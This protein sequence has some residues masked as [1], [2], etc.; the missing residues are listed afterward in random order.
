M[1]L[2]ATIVKDEQ[3]ALGGTPAA[4]R[5]T[6]AKTSSVDISNNTTAQDTPATAATA[7]DT[8]VTTQDTPATTATAGDTPVAS[9]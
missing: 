3:T 8:L 4:G 1:A 7:G 5:L 6:A 9:A 2:D